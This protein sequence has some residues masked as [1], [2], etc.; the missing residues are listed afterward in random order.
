MP[1]Y[2]ISTIIDLVP[3]VSDPLQLPNLFPYISIDSRAD[4]SDTM[5]RS[6]F[7]TRY[8]STGLRAADETAALAKFLLCW[9]TFKAMHY[10]DFARI[11]EA[12]SENYDMLY[13]YDKTIS[14]SVTTNY[15]AGESPKGYAEHR[16]LQHGEVITTHDGTYKETTSTAPYDGSPIE[17]QSSERGHKTA[18]DNNTNTHSGTDTDTLSKGL[19]EVA[20]DMHEYGNIGIQTVADIL[21]KEM[22]L[23]S[24]SMF[25]A[26]LDSFVREYLCT[27]W[28]GEGCY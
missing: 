18:N 25:Q 21:L 22:K 5:V 3:A 6:T 7:K 13:N 12:E 20:T 11:C 28:L 24:E 17:T 23:R 15:D 9:E 1:M 26:Y 8:A 14:G 19:Q 27:F 10:D 4:Y 16:S 2:D